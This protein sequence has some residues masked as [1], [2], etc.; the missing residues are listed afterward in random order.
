MTRWVRITAVALAVAVLAAGCAGGRLRARGAVSPTPAGAAVTPPGAAGTSDPATATAPVTG[1][2]AGRPYAAYLPPGLGQG[3]VPLVLFLHGGGGNATNA[4]ATTC[5]GGDLASPTCLQAVG[6]RAGFITVYASGTPNRVLSSLRTWNAGGG[7]PAYACASGYACDSGADD[8]GY[9]RS[10]LAQ[11]EQRYPVDRARVYVMGFSNG[12]AMAHRVA[13]EMADRVAAVV[14]VSGENEY[15]TNAHCAPSRPITV[16]D[17]H[18]TDDECWTYRTSTT[19]CADQD[20]R[21]KVGVS[22]SMAGWVSRDRCSAASTSTTLP[23]RA[24]DGM[25]TTEQVWQCADATQVR[26]LR[27]AG[28]RHVFPGGSKVRT[29]ASKDVATRDFGAADLWERVSVFRLPT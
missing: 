4:Q 28:G 24:E 11:L 29:G 21:P 3:P 19:A 26:L 1:T 12:G 10:L 23:D 9:L 6:A 7:G 25:T 22:Q 20:P 14:P 2:L 18:G 15:A 5:A 8:I 13:C 27:I 16:I 17:V